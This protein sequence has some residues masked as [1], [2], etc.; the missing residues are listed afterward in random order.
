MTLEA[1]IILGKG[2]QTDGTVP[3]IVQHE[4]DYVLSLH[5][6]QPLPLVIVSGRQWGLEP[7][8][9]QLSEAVAMANYLKEQT[10]SNITVEL[11]DQ[12][13]DTIGNLV[14]S[15]QILDTHQA[16]QILVVSTV[17]HLS[18]VQYL[19]SQLFD[20]SYHFSYHGH[21]HT[22]TPLEYLHTWRYEL[23]SKVYAHWFLWKFRHQAT[24]DIIT[25]LEHHHFMYRQG[26][27]RT[28]LTWLV[29]RPVHR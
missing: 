19:V 25:Y 11:E 1:V 16:K 20:A 26:W 27:L 17:P 7:V 9:G 8:H 10:Q 28:G 24:H 23:C 3:T 18:R 29:Q 14:F 15:K 22:Y 13:L 6:Q 12:S 21:Q 4:L 2:V 5:G